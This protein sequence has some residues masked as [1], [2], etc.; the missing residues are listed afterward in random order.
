M[1]KVF[2]WRRQWPDTHS[3]ITENF[4]TIGLKKSDV[5]G[6]WRGK[7]DVIHTGVQLSVPNFWKG[8]GS[9][10]PPAYHSGVVQEQLGTTKT[11]YGR[12]RKSFLSFQC[13]STI[14]LTGGWSASQQY[15]Y[16]HTHEHLAVSF[17]VVFLQSMTY[18]TQN[19]TW[20]AYALSIVILTRALYL[21][22]Y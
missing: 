11:D 6:L 10:S 12:R 5:K 7:M 9:A 20:A 2:I 3:W 14:E 15:I 22:P 1:A 18:I 4:L 19:S 17:L 16:T 8:S 13:S 21:L